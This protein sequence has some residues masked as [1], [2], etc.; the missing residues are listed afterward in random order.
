MFME[1]PLRCI[2]GSRVDVLQ[3]KLFIQENHDCDN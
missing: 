1:H 2:N 3:W